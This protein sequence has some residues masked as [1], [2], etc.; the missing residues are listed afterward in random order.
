MSAAGAAIDAP[1]HDARWGGLAPHAGYVYSGFTAA[2]LY[3]SVSVEPETVAFCGSVHVRGLTCSALDAHREWQ[4]PLGAIAPDRTLG[5]AILAA[6]GDLAQANPVAHDQD[7]AIEVQLP[8]VQTLWPAARFVAMTVP[9]DDRASALGEAIAAAARS[10]GRRILLVASSDLT[11]YGER[12]GF[13][14]FGSGEAALRRAHGQN[15]LELL[16]RLEAM[17]PAG[18][19]AHAGQNRSACGGGALA[20]VWTAAARLGATGARVLAQTSS[21][22]EEGDPRAAASVGYGA[23][24]LVG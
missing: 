8:F 3:A 7:H 14:P 22:A 11:H 23:V 24:T 5:D 13:T 12:F 18:A 1:L 19:L 20:A 15:D 4:T 9:A 16:Q 10:T 2:A 21:S 17:D 6:A